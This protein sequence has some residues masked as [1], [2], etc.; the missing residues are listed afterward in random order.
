MA[1]TV[2][3]GKS[4]VV[5]TPLGLGTNKVGGHNLFPNLI[6]EQGAEVVRAALDNGIQMLDTAFM[7]GLGRSEEII[8]NVIKD[9]DRHQIVLATKAAQDPHQELKP[10]NQPQFLTKAV[11]DA[12]LR[13]RTDYI[14]VFYIHFPD[15]DTPKYEAVGALEKAKEAGKIR[16][17]GVSNFSLDQ[18][19]EA[20]QD[21]YVD[22][23]EG[24]YS[25]IH[26]DA[27]QGDFAYLK[28]NDI[29]FVPYEPLALGLLTGKYKDAKA[30]GEGD[31]Q[32]DHDSAN[33]SG[34]RFYQNV[35][36]VEK[37]RP[38]ADRH[39]V[40]VADVFLAWYM[41]NP[42]ISVVIPG[43]RKPEQVVENAKA[44]DLRLSADEYQLID[45]TFKG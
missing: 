4:D 42:N 7:Y 38:I 18:I 26:R 44:L 28:A 32:Y 43:A 3:I 14:D 17:I 15:K 2:K 23:V 8:G 11:D 13:L 27:E 16:A 40:S 30:F 21:N 6:D 34:D 37:I 31:W 22:I 41:A 25:L 19:K 29:S 5:S 45:E 1:K 36:A 35:A 10:N 20:N 39:N 9:Y 24:K 33:F 12:L